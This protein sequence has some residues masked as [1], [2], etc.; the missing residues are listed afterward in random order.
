MVIIVNGDDAMI[1]HASG[2]R[3]DE[4]QRREDG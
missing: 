2:Y 3:W 1:I 4:E